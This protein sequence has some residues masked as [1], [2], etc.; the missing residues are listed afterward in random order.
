[1]VMPTETPHSPSRLF[2]KQE[3]LLSSLEDTHPINNIVSKCV[4]LE[5]GEYISCKLLVLN[6]YVLFVPYHLKKI[7]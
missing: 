5:H 2:Y 3:V 7:V 6:M 1:M 4:V